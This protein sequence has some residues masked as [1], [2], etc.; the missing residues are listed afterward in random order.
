MKMIG[1]Y[2]CSI[3]TSEK[4]QLVIML[5]GKKLYILSKELVFLPTQFLNLRKA[6][7]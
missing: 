1:K 4:F 7:I 3:K 2:S 6:N 5:Y